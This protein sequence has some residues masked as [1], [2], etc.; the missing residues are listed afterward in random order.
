M[1]KED[2]L[3]RNGNRCFLY[4]DEC[5]TRVYLDFLIKRTGK[6]FILISHTRM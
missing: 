3:V 5:D 2:I 1:M 6:I 4:S